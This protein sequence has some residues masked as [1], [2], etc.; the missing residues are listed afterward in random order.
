MGTENNRP[1]SFRKGLWQKRK[2]KGRRRGSPSPNR[3]RALFASS[4]VATC[5]VWAGHEDYKC[6]GDSGSRGGEKSGILDGLCTLSTCF[7]TSALQSGVPLFI[8]IFVPSSCTTNVTN[9]ACPRAKF[10]ARRFQ[11][12]CSMP[13]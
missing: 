5:A 10:K 9:S 6:L 7:V 2:L 3:N 12:G 1:S 13:R 8:S 11:V 4:L